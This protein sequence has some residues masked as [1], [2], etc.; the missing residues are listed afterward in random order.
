MT[1]TLEQEREA[2]EKWVSE[3][4]WFLATLYLARSGD[5]YADPGIN[6]RWQGWKAHH[7][8]QPAQAVDT[9]PFCRVEDVSGFD[10]DSTLA[11]L[12]V[13]RGDPLF[14]RDIGT[15]QEGLAAEWKSTPEHQTNMLLARTV[16]REVIVPPAPAPTPPTDGEVKV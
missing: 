12:G 11:Q 3:Q 8:S 10:N 4:P 14:T 6:S 9:V 5:E 16:L 7:L 15:A 13:K 2:F 1:M